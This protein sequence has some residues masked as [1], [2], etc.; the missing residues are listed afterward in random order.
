MLSALG[1]S[2]GAYGETKWIPSLS[3]SERYDSNVFFAPGSLVPG[4]KLWDFVTAATPSI[5]VEHKGRPVEGTLTASASGNVYMN[6][7]GLN[8]VSTNVGLD[9]NMNELV[10]RLL[11]GTTLRVTD[12]FLYTPQPPAFLT[13]QLGPG[14][15]PYVIGIQAF[16]AN[17]SSNSGSVAGTY[18]WLPSTDLE[19]SYT[20]S[21]IRFGSTFVSGTQ[22]TLLNS[23]LQRVTGGFTFRISARDTTNLLYQYSEARYEVFPSFTTH[24]VSVSYTRLLTPSATLM[25]GG[26]PTVVNPGNSL[27]YTGTASLSWRATQADTLRVLYTRAFAPSFFL[28]ASALVSNTVTGTVTHQLGERLNL[29]AS[30][31]YAQSES[32]PTQVLSFRSFGA[33]A[34]VN[35]QLTRWISASV[36]YDYSDF[37]NQFQGQSFAF[38]RNVATLSLKGSWR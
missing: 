26:G 11:P 17:S 32:V 4:A 7:S 3:L 1:L 2:S 24:G 20:N 30:A 29:T 38:D 36:A 12:S 16:R 28:T 27:N 14:A 18:R 9:L 10:G 21:L 13:P 35:Y 6:N 33:S 8:Y 22:S 34:S 25:V 5:A 31:N 19:T 23:N 37:R 15:N